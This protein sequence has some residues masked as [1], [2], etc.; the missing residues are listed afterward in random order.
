[1]C[2]GA[3]YWAGI[4]TVVFGLAESRLVE[5][6]GDNPKNLTLDLS[7]RA[8]FA[9]GQRPVAVRGPFPELEEEIV[10]GHKDFW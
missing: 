3:S 7:C 10:D 6:T 1:M 8:V 5:M 4:G 2:S 9:A